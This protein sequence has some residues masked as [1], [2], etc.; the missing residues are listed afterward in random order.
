MNRRDFGRAIGL[1]SLSPGLAALASP[2]VP[3]EGTEGYVPWYRKLK[4]GIEIGPTGDNDGDDIFMSKATG[5]E[6]IE[7]CVAANAEYVVLFMK[8]FEFAFYDSRIAQQCPNLKGRDLLR[9]CFDEAAK[10]EMPI[11]VYQ[12][13]QYDSAAWR[14]FPAYRMQ[15]APLLPVRALPAELACRAGGGDGRGSPRTTRCAG[16]SF[17]R[18]SY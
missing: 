2:G 15:D 18:P 9:E 10:H 4:V 12:Q 1:A 8:D 13:I 17:R 5:K 11:I 16:P 6:W 14:K 7:Q 3:A